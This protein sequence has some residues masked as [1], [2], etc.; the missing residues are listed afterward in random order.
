MH[1]IRVC[2][3]THK[4]TVVWGVKCRSEAP[5]VAGTASVGLVYWWCSIEVTQIYR[6]RRK[7][8]IWGL[9]LIEYLNSFMSYT[10]GCKQPLSQLKR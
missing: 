6:A 1:S 2:R 3:F 7:P 4:H 8:A 5:Q 10:A 9:L